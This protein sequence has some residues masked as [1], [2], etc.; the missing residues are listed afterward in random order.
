MDLSVIKHKIIAEVVVFVRMFAE[1][2]QP[3]I[4]PELQQDKN[5]VVLVAILRLTK[6]FLL[7]LDDRKAAAY[8]LAIIQEY[9]EYVQAAVASGFVSGMD[10]IDKDLSVILRYI[11]I[12]KYHPD[13]VDLLIKNTQDTVN[14]FVDVELISAPLVSFWLQATCTMDDL[15]KMQALILFCS[16]EEQAKIYANDPSLLQNNISACILRKSSMVQVAC[17]QKDTS[18]ALIKLISANLCTVS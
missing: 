2:Y 16:R 1:N 5:K 10:C 9:L 6:N 7:V 12:I 15:R 8:K 18:G 11:Q 17:N 4:D 13:K 3:S 14:K